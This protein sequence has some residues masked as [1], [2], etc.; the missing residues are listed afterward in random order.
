MTLTTDK[1]LELTLDCRNDLK[2]FEDQVANFSK[3]SSLTKEEYEQNNFVCLDFHDRMK[4]KIHLLA[5]MLETNST[6]ILDMV[7]QPSTTPSIP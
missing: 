1:M 5:T 6:D 7:T 2:L 3:Y 4:R